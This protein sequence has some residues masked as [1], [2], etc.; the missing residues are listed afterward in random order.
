MILAESAELI[1]S[2]PF[3]IWLMDQLRALAAIRVPFLTT[4]MSAVTYLGHEMVFLVVAMIIA[5]CVDKKYGYRFLGIFM[6]GSFLQQALKA[7]FMIP[8]PWIIDP[9]FMAVA[10]AIPAASGYSFPSGHTLTAVVTLGGLAGC[11]KKKWAYACAIILSLVVAFSRMYLGVHTLLDVSVGFLLGVLVLVFF[12]LMFRNHQNDEKR[13][14]AVLITGAVACVGLLVWLL[15]RPA[16]ADPSFLPMA[17]ESISN[18]YVLVGASVGML[19]GKLLDDRFVRFET[20]AGFWAQVVKVAVGLAVVLAVR[21]ALKKVFGG[22][23]ETPLLHGVRYL[24]MTV[25]AI[26]IY[27]LLFKYFNRIGSR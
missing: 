13:M 12:A 1:G 22:D 27:P 7:A 3:F 19:I 15:V 10:N 17:Q 6:I 21:F 25:V 20:K 5:W 8:R 24:V 9:S 4:V 11:L 16:P 14:N 23:L 18:A 2:S 26:G